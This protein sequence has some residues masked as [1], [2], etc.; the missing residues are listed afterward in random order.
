M[1][2]ILSVSNEG[3]FINASCAQNLTS[4]FY[5]Y[6]LVDATAVRLLVPEGI[7]RP[8]VSASVLTWFIKLYLQFLNN[9]IIIKTKVLLPQT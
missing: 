3:Y 5:Y 7:I 4:T 9:V 8:I 2:V 6:H 1:K